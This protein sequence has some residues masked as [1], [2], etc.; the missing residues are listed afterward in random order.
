MR[1]EME[2]WLTATAAESVGGAH[3]LCD[4]Y[5]R[6]CVPLS[7]SAAG[8]GAEAALLADLAPLADRAGLRD[9]LASV[10]G[11]ARC[12]WDARRQRRV[13]FDDDLARVP[14]RDVDVAV[15]W[16][17]NRHMW[18]T[19][20]WGRSIA[21]IAEA[22]GWSSAEAAHRAIFASGSF[23]YI[24]MDAWFRAL[25][26][27]PPD[28]LRMLDAM[29]DPPIAD[30]HEH[31]EARRWV[32]MDSFAAWCEADA[33]GRRPVMTF[34]EQVAALPPLLPGWT[35]LLDRYGDHFGRPWVDDLIA[36]FVAESERA[37]RGEFD[38]I[39]SGGVAAIAWDV[40]EYSRIE[41][42]LA[43]A[44]PP[45]QDLKLDVNAVAQG[46]KAVSDL[47][48]KIDAALYGFMRESAQH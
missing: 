7:L 44:G 24:W 28:Q 10:F 11:A 6:T 38:R 9:S 40:N 4:W 47:T 18:S 35:E 2:R 41:L 27:I 33:V 31:Q 14:G 20:Q 13:L 42:F 3:R 23:N 36:R 21:A 48:S 15:V 45:G 12:V 39:V 1:H 17:V 30:W 34:E 37:S 32:L 22:E 25:R 46:N 26:V 29:P 19:A 43:A 5:V 16:A 8:F